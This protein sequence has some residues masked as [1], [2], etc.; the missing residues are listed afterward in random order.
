MVEFLGRNDPTPGSGLLVPRSQWVPTGI[1]S[2]LDSLLYSGQSEDTVPVG[3]TPRTESRLRLSLFLVWP[4]ALVAR[5][6]IFDVFRL[7]PSQAISIFLLLVW[8]P[9]GF[10]PMPW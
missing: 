9:Y 5:P 1:G 3:R 7:V 2:T 4:G 8:G 10:R 6:Y